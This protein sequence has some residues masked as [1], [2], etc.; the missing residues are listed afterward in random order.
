[1][2]L[3]SYKEQIAEQLKAYQSKI[4][5]SDAF[6]SLKERYDNLNPNIQNLLKY[7]ALFFVIYFFYSIP[8]S[9]VVSAEEKMEFFSDNRML[10]RDLIRA[11]RISRTL[12]LPPPAPPVEQLKSQ[13]ESKLG[14]ERVLPSQKLGSTSVGNVAATS[15]VP[16]SIN[17]SG[18]KT[19]LKS[20]NLKQV[21]RIGEAIS[22]IQGAEL[23]NLS[24]RADKPD[25]HY[26]NVEYEVAAFSVPQ[27]RQSKPKSKKKSSKK[28]QKGR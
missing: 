27:P 19:S 3:E 13:I 12:Q 17:Q 21:V 15:I 20:L 4:Q 25:P 11:G 28:K 16:K 22:N 7:A 18:L 10:T 23:I 1:M 14:V 6:I 2:D 5:D 8:S 9:F 24:I 26:F